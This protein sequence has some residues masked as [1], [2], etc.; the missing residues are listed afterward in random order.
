MRVAWGFAIVFIFGY[1]SGYRV[2]S[3]WVVL[4]GLMEGKRKGRSGWVGRV[5]LG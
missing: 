5:K 2:K 3:G 4:V 1:K